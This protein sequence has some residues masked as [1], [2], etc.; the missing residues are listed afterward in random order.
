MRRFREICASFVILVIT[1][2]ATNTAVSDTQITLACE[3]SASVTEI[4]RLTIGASIQNLPSVEWGIRQG[5]FKKYGLTVKSAPVATFPLGLAG[6][7]SKSYDLYGTTPVN[8]LKAIADGTFKGKIVASK[9][10]Y[11][12]PELERVKQEPLYPGE[13]LMGTA[14]IVKKSSNIFSYKDLVGKK[15]AI[16]SFQGADHAGIL[17]AMRELGIRNPK[18]E[19][20]AMSNTQMS[21]VLK[22]GDVDAV[23]SADP[24]ASQI[25]H[26]FGRLVAYPGIYMQE[27]GTAFVFITSEET[28]KEKTLAL[29]AFQKA[30]LEINRLL[31][32]PENEASY[33]KT[34]S[35]VSK[36]SQEV[37]NKVRITVFS[38]NNVTISQLAYLPSRLKKVGFYK[39]RFELGPVLFR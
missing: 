36:V 21:D 28:S 14:L 13:L 37:A 3:S 4:G 20:L 8:F 9:Y 7:I 19:F 12:A 27:I 17:L 35:E 16:L 32:K 23:V 30:N 6:L 22:N 29:R 25:I 10:G 33:R 2:T 5:C 34:L 1:I 11:T 26:D 31:N 24:I 18:I 39:G 15:I 38:E